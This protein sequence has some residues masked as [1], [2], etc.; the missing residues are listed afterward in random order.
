VKRLTKTNARSNFIGGSKKK[1]PTLDALKREA[2]A[3]LCMLGVVLLGTWIVMVVG[4]Q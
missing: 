2:V 4:S 1:R 3:G